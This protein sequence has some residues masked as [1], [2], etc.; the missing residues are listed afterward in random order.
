MMF[1]V[2]FG[3]DI[4]KF[5]KSKRGTNSIWNLFLFHLNLAKT[6]KPK[7]TTMKC[8]FD[9]AKIHAFFRLTSI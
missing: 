9:G 3:E 8:R 6:I 7:T 2:V 5:L 4:K 1:L